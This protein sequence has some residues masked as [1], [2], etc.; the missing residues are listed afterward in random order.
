LKLRKK[1]LNKCV[2]STKSMG[3]EAPEKNQTNLL[4]EERKW[5]LKIWKKLNKFV[6]SVKKMGS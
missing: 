5:V 4:D 6:G 3:L 1:T 2:G